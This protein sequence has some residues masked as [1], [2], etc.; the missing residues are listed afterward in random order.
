MTPLPTT[1]ASPTAHAPPRHE[2][3]RIGTVSM[4]ALWRSGTPRERGLIFGAWL[5]SILASVGFG[6]ATVAWGWSGIPLLFGG[7]KVFITIYPPLVICQLWTLCFGW[8]WG[9]LPAYLATLVLALYAGMPPH[10]ALLFAWAN[11]LGFAVLSLGYRAMGPSR[12]LRSLRSWLFYVQMCFVAGVFS[13]AGAL[14]WCYTNQIDTIGQLPIWQGWWLGA[15]LQGVLIAAPLMALAWPAIERWQQR[16]PALCQRESADPRRL[17]LRLT[18]AVVA[19]VVGYGFLSLRMGASRVDE[20]LRSGELALLPAAAQVM[21]STTW[22]FFWVF[23]LIVV[24][25][26][27]F[28]YKVFVRWMDETDRL[29]ARLEHANS[30]L[31]VLSRTDGLT[32]LYNRATIDAL[33]Q[34]AW[35]RAKR[36]G[37]QPC[38]LLILDLAHFKQIND[39]FGHTLGDA[40][41]RS[42]AAAMRESTRGADSIGRFGGEEFIVILPATDAAGAEFLAE[43][44][45]L[46]IAQSELRSAA[47][48]IRFTVSIGAADFRV[49]DED[50]AAWLRR[51]D[52]AL[53]RAKAAGRNRTHLAGDDESHKAA[54]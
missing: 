4:R 8:W 3:A 39:R 44:I 5:T 22:V 33:L 35:Q 26:G 2:V 25:V 17:A 32:G 41:I 34:E 9:A 54:S 37:E 23:A 40:V 15:F 30:E 38:S 49:Q 27:L 50:A 14:I 31:A 21:L 29:V 46:R 51:A 53:Y 13:S 42:V 48:P 36:F 19:G 20:T 16:R 6:L 28:G 24:F 11:P 43:R 10:W 1:P 12:G 18:L 47:G 45:R 7:V 52:A